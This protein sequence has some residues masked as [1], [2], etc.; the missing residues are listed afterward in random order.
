MVH[1]KR[2][3]YSSC[4]NSAIR[5]L[6]CDSSTSWPSTSSLARSL[7]SPCGKSLLIHPEQWE[8]LVGIARTM[9]EVALDASLSEIQGCAAVGIRET[10]AARLE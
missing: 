10:G 8:L 5:R 7:A 4:L 9:K 6:N 3:P 1:S 2:L